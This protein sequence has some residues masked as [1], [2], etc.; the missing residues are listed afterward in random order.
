[1]LD[2]L[3]NDICFIIDKK[4]KKYYL[5]TLSEAKLLELRQCGRIMRC[6]SVKIDLEREQ[7]LALEGKYNIVRLQQDDSL[8][9]RTFFCHVNQVSKPISLDNKFV[10]PLEKVTN[11]FQ[12]ALSVLRVYGCIEIAGVRYNGYVGGIP[13][14][15]SLLLYNESG[16]VVDVPLI[17]ASSIRKC[18][19]NETV[20]M[21]MSGVCRY[22]DKLVTLNSAILREYYGSILDSRLESKGV[23]YRNCMYDVMLKGLVK[24]ISYY[25][26]SFGVEEDNVDDMLTTCKSYMKKPVKAGIHARRLI[27]ANQILSGKASL[28]CTI[29]EGAE[30]SPVKNEL[31]QYTVAL[32]NEHFGYVIEKPMA[33]DIKSARASALAEAKRK[34]GGKS[35]ILSVCFKGRVEEGYTLFPQLSMG[36]LTKCYN[37]I[38]SGYVNGFDSYYRNICLMADECSVSGVNEDGVKFIFI[39]GLAKKYRKEVDLDFGF[40]VTSLVKYFDA[41]ASGSIEKELE[42]LGKGR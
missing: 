35:S 14:S 32:A 29:P 33:C 18:E 19:Q 41:C 39:N 21:L 40:F 7:R 28:Y 6:G 31:S 12:Y 27:S 22:K 10:M 1:M 20:K 24:N 17:T 26:L 8:R 9:M 3:L 30:L 2:L 15:G 25:K 5:G 4:T 37:S 23:R 34:Y 36:V 42:K 11:I 16:Q 38:R 13:T